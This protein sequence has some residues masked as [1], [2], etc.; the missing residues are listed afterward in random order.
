MLK[1]ALGPL[2]FSIAC[3]VLCAGCSLSP[4]PN[5]ASSNTAKE[6]D[7]AKGNVAKDK[8]RTDQLDVTLKIEN[9]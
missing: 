1:H 8:A 9:R 6:L 4:A 7:N 5:P 2:A 3:V